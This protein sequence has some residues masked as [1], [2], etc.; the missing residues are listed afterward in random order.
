MKKR[1]PRRGIAI[2]FAIGLMLLTLAFSTLALTA[3][4]LRSR[5]TKQD[6]EGFREKIL[7]MQFEDLGE[8]N[9]DLK[10]NKK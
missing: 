4:M 3:S 6:L 1:D 2:E 10:I 7:A 5:R 8:E 9:P